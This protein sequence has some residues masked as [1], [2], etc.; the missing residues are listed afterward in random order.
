[1]NSPP[2][3]RPSQASPERPGAKAAGEV[4]L[5]DF[6]GDGARRIPR[7]LAD[8]LVADGVCDRV[9]AAGHVRLKLG[10]RSV[11][12]CE[13]SNGQPDLNELRRR[14]PER[15]AANWRGSQHPHIGR[16][17]LGRTAIDETVFLRP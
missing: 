8:R 10:I 11:L 1:V 6:G 3:A 4:W 7:A 9:S 13:G 14:Q 12:D 16:G 5:R 15:Y 17:A 2:A